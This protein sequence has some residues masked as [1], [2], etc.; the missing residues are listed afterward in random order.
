MGASAGLSDAVLVPN[1]N[2]FVPVLGEAAGVVL[3][4]AFDDPVLAPKPP[5]PVLGAVEEAPAEAAP[6]KGLGD[7][8]VGPPDGTLNLN[9][10]AALAIVDDGAGDGDGAVDLLASKPKAELEGFVSAVVPD[11]AA[12]AGLGDELVGLLEKP[13][14]NLGAGAALEVGA[15][16]EAP[17]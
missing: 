6:P 8:K 17:F 9:L 11:D 10:G 15:A 12:G 2:V 7:P 16:V 5:K 1:P 4:K 3:P 13:K 14:L